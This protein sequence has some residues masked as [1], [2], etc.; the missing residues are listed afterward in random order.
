MRTRV[1]GRARHDSLFKRLLRAFFPDLLQLALPAMAGHLDVLGA[2][3]LDKELF[4]EAGRR[5]EPDLLARIPL[6]TSE[7]ESLLVHVEIEARARGPIVGRLRQYRR[8][9]EATY[10]SDVVSI[11]VNL[12]GGEPGLQVRPLPGVTIGPGLGSQ[13]VA[14]GLSGCDAEVYLQRP[15]PLAWAL[16]A[17]MSPRK[18]GRAKLKAA[19]LSRIADARLSEDSRILLVDCVATYLELT[20]EETSEYAT[21]DIGGG[22]R[23]MRLAE[24]SWGDRL[25]AEG[26]REGIEQGARKVLLRLLGQRF[27]RV[28]VSVRRRVEEIDS[29]D[30][31]IRLAERVL[32]ARSL[33]DLGLAP[34]SDA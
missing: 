21:S 3:F 20:P 17:L 34:R 30:N 18:L 15:E 33:E 12:R 13:Y 10:D 8:R 6:L 16:A 23:T 19:C 32:T 5:R 24:M 9:I 29:V 22:N 31:L 28:P 1:P 27:G 7:P 14:F 26:R 25:R 11:V 2:V 4:T